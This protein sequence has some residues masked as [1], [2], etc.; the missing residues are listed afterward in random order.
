MPY[1]YTKKKNDKTALQKFSIRW[2]SD[3]SPKISIEVFTSFSN[4]F[5]KD[6]SY[7]SAVKKNHR[8][9]FIQYKYFG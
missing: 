4:R 2:F 1:I 9:Q 7:I 3:S 6:Y 5:F 8:L